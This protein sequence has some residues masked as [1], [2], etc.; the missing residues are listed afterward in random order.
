MENADLEVFSYRHLHRSATAPIQEAS[1]IKTIPLDCTRKRSDGPS[2]S[3]HA[4]LPRYIRLFTLRALVHS[5]PTLCI[6]S[7]SDTV[8]KP[9]RPSHDS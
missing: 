5:S 1:H 9:L 2:P 7:S 4:I 8:L 3:S 6:L